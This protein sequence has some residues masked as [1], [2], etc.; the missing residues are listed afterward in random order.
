MRDTNEGVW[1]LDASAQVLSRALVNQTATFSFCTLAWVG[2]LVLDVNTLF[3]V[4]ILCAYR[5][6]GK[7]IIIQH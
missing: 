2:G 3:M 5:V 1:V 4:G 7:K 6:D